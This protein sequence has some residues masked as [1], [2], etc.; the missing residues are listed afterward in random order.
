MSTNSELIIE[1]SNTFDNGISFKENSELDFTFLI[2]FLVFGLILA[3]IRKPL[4]NIIRGTNCAISKDEMNVK[5][6]FEEKVTNNTNIIKIEVEGREFIVFESNVNVEVVDI[7][8]KVV[9]SDE[10]KN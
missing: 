5:K 1:R 8:A 4:M 3:V 2:I 9:R 7:V 10:N 6:V